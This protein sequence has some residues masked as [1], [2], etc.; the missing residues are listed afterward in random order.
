MKALV[1]LAF[2][3]I[4]AA[5]TTPGI[6]P[7]IQAQTHTLATAR[8]VRRLAPL[9]ASAAPLEII[10]NEVRNAAGVI[11]VAVFADADS[12]PMPHR[13]VAHRVVQPRNGSVRT[14][15]EDLPSG[16]YAVAVF[17]DENDNQDFDLRFGI[18]PR[19]GYGFSNDAHALLRPP[20]FEQAA[21]DLSPK[22]VRVSFDMVYPGP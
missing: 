5:C 6:G 13:D 16:R 9:P 15:I 11:Y 20:E 17:H 21:F 2:I 14:L 3:G 4:L 12:F 1:G 19:E 18:L 7:Q 8:E 10:I 22:G